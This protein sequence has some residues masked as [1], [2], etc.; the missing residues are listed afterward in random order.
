MVTSD[1]RFI[2]EGGQGL[3][4]SPHGWRETRPGSVVAALRVRRIWW[5]RS[6]TPS[7][8]YE[9]TGKNLPSG[10]RLQRLGRGP[11]AAQ[12]PCR[13]PGSVGLQR[14]VED[15][16]RKPGPHVI[17]SASGWNQVEMGRQ[18]RFPLGRARGQ[19]W[20]GSLEFSPGRYESS[21]FFLCFLFY[22]VC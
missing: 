16:P 10:P 22:F 3:K 21:F 13:F 17:V 14:E 11:E 18:V 20:A 5:R 15:D 1:Q 12:Q 7:S 6:R 4:P 8:C 9:K 2:E 19:Y